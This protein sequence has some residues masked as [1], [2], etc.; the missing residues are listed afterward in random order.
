[1]PPH[2]DSMDGPVVLAAREALETGDVERVLPYVPAS[3]EPEVREAFGRTR[4]VRAL[5]AEAREV[6]DRWFFETAVRV[7]RAGEGAPYTGLK[8][9]GGDFGPVIPVAERA[10]E[11]GGADE[12]AGVLCGIVR[13]QVERRLA[14]AMAL[15]ERAGDGDRDFA[16]GPLLRR[17]GEPELRKHG[18]GDGAGERDDAGRTHYGEFQ[19]HHRG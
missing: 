2:C 12:L 10:L 3:G 5:G 17:D 4:T 18:E 11:T 9:A 16:V 7:H 13:E 8:P 1:M 6:A 19:H 15:R 14:R